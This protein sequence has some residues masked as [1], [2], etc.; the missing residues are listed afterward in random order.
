MNDASVKMGET[1][2]TSGNHRFKYEEGY[3]PHQTTIP[4]LHTSSSLIGA[5]FTI[6][7]KSLENV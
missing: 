5:S 6:K 4:K 2:T 3:L 7:G 1:S